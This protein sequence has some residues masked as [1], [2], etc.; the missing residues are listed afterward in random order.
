MFGLSIFVCHRILVQRLV[1]RLV[2][3]VNENQMLV[4]W[5]WWCCHDSVPL[6]PSNSKTPSTSKRNKWP[7]GRDRPPT[8]DHGPCRADHASHQ[9]RAYHCQWPLIVVA[10][11]RHHQ[12]S[13][14]NSTAG[15]SSD[16]KCTINDKW[17]KTSLD[18]KVHP[19][20]MQEYVSESV[21][22]YLQ[23]NSAQ[24]LIPASV[25]MRLCHC[26]PW[27]WDAKLTPMPVCWRRLRGYQIRQRSEHLV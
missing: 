27:N 21:S 9:H 16:S 20:D 8:M 11:P 18:K 4:Q 24:E 2:F 26:R 12:A 17:H 14:A 13:W 25:I 5:E 7:A 23:Q 3:Q 10:P 19:P 15:P 1:I 22:Q 6:D